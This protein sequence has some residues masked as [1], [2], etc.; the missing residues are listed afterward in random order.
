MA[1]SCVDG[2]QA[3]GIYTER[4]D[5]PIQTLEAV[6][7]TGQK[8]SGLAVGALGG[9]MHARSK[10]QPLRPWIGQPRSCGRGFSRRAKSEAPGRHEYLTRRPI[11]AFEWHLIWLLSMQ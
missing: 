11:T 9:M 3:I 5:G 6:T 8:R 1:T 10:R 4:S 7:M 2:V